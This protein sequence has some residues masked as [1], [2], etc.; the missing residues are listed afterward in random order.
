MFHH[1]VV[2]RDLSHA[3]PGSGHGNRLVVSKSFIIFEMHLTD[4]NLYISTPDV[5]AHACCLCGALLLTETYHMT[6]T[7][8]YKAEHISSNMISGRIMAKQNIFC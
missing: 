1:V 3:R 5:G 2:K 4:M 6:K 8:A 7:T